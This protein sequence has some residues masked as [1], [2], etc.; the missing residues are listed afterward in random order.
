[1]PRPKKCRR[2]C[3]PPCHDRFGPRGVSD[4]M[5]C[6]EMSLDEYETIRLIDLLGQTQE[7]CGRQMEVARTTVQAMYDSARRK[8]AD[9]LVNGRDLHIRGGQVRIC[10]HGDR[11]GGGG[12]RRCHPCSNQE[13]RKD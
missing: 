8:L 5:P 4:G 10:P 3:G 9:A 1:M 13:K 2:I 12:G 6:V 11:C 7:E